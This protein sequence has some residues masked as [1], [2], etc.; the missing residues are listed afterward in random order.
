MTTLYEVL[1]VSTEASPEIVKAAYE[2]LA[3]SIVGSDLDVENRRKALNEAFLTLGNA[4]KRKRYDQRLASRM[5]LVKQ[6][7]TQESRTKY[8][9]IGAILL[10]CAFGYIKYNQNQETARIERERIAAELRKAELQAQ[11]EAEQRRT[12]SERLR[13][14]RQA[15]Q[16]QRYAFER[17]RRESDYNMRQNAAAAE[18]A[19]REDENR[20]R[21]E[22]RQVQVAQQN[23]QREALRRL[24]REKALARQL[25][26]ENSRNRRI[27]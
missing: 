2:R 5:A 12:E 7:S 24:E 27:F 1:Q 19:R 25:E 18:R 6:D 8:L 13:A 21:M 3:S 26:N 14:E 9:L 17:D 22:E 10:A 11:Q 16:Q 15:E 20:R 23:E 4:E